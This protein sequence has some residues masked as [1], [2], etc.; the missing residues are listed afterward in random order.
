VND[1]TSGRIPIGISSKH[2]SQLGGWRSGELRE[3]GRGSLDKA[4]DLGTQFVE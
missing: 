4:H 1:L 2:P 3:L